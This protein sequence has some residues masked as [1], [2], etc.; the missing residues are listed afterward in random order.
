MQEG[1]RLQ[2]CSL[3]F[4]VLSVQTIS[5]GLYSLLTCSLLPV[6]VGKQIHSYEINENLMEVPVVKVIPRYVGQCHKKT[7]K[8]CWLKAALLSAQGTGHF[9]Q[10]C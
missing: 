3:L 7:L 6:Q 5:S 4:A 1:K 8:E 9:V 10:L 2:V